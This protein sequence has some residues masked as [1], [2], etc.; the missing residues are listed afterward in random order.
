MPTPRPGRFFKLSLD[1]LVVKFALHLLDE[2]ASVGYVDYEYL[3]LTPDDF[4]RVG[5]KGVEH[6]T[7][8]EQPVD[9]VGN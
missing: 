4:V 8:L 3:I 2:R 9:M 1:P 6:S 7:F 5:V